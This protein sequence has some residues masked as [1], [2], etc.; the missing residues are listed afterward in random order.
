MLD[1]GLVRLTLAHAGLYLTMM[2]SGSLVDTGKANAGGANTTTTGT[3]TATAIFVNM[4]VDET[5]TVTSLPTNRTHVSL[6]SSGG[7][8]HEH[9]Q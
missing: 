5:T 7:E 9:A 3:G 8:L 2:D 4:T 1:T 6:I